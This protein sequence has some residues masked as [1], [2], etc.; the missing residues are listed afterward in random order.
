MHTKHIG[1]N[2]AIFSTFCQKYNDRLDQPSVAHYGS[3]TVNAH[4]VRSTLEFNL[5]ITESKSMIEALEQHIEHI[6]QLQQ[7]QEVSHV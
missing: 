1:L 2:A 3:I 5:G 7:Q 6:Q 4:G